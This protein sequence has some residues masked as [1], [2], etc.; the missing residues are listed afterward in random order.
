MS[1]GP[2]GPTPSAAS[3]QEFLAGH[4][5]NSLLAGLD[6]LDRLREAAPQ[7]AEECIWTATNRARQLLGDIQVGTEFL[8][9]LEARNRV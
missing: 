2:P 6:S 3:H 5:G 7:V 8:E 4:P 1:R 9:L